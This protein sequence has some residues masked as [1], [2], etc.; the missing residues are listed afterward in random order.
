MRAGLITFVTGATGITGRS[1]GIRVFL[2]FVVVSVLSSGDLANKVNAD[3][4]F[5]YFAALLLCSLFNSC[6]MY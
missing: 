6:F 2:F 3:L 5:L 4:Y 1:S